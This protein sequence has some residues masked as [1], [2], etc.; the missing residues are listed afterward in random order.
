MNYGVSI[1]CDLRSDVERDL[2]SD[3]GKWIR[4]RSHNLRSKDELEIKTCTKSS[5]SQEKMN[6][7]K[8]SDFGG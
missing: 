6:H 1:W 2:R 3:S 7:V 4:L 8:Y 5:S